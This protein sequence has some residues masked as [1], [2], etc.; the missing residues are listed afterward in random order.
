MQTA[1][2]LRANIAAS[3]APKLFSETALDAMGIADILVN[4]AGEIRHMNQL[5]ATLLKRANGLTVDN[6][7][8]KAIA[9]QE[10]AQLK[11]LIVAATGEKLASASLPGG[12]MKVLVPHARTSLQVSVVPAPEQF[13]QIGG[14]YALVF[15]GDPSSPPKSRAPL[16]RQ[17]YR[18]TPVEA[19]LSDLLLQGLEV[20]DAAEQLGTTLQTARFHLKRVLAKTDTRRQTELMRLMLSLP[21]MPDSPFRSEN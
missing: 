20:R 19:R 5:A 16:M 7:R 18:L 1:L 4:C 8:L 14:S 13:H 11:F 6:G 12:A 2:L 9:P 10:N 21:G 3:H 15:I 17:L